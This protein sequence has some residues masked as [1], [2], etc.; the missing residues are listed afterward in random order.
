M[1]VEVKNSNLNFSNCF[2]FVIANKLFEI[3]I[4]NFQKRCDNPIKNYDLKRLNFFIILSQ[5]KAY[6]SW[7]TKQLSFSNIFTLYKEKYDF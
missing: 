5:G 3:F 7:H 2:F 1:G 6:R 4:F